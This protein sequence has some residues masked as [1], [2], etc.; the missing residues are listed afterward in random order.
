MTTPTQPPHL[1]RGVLTVAASM[2]AGALLL[3]TVLLTW[4]D[5]LGVA[6]VE[7]GLRVRGAGTRPVYTVTAMPMLTDARRVREVL[8]PI[9]VDVVTQ[10]A[11]ALCGTVP[12][13]TE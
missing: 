5:P 1:A 7:L 11:L 12:G 2:L 8:Q 4:G 10:E 3:A 6:M 13:G 9:A